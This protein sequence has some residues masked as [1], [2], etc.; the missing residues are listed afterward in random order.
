M[1]GP[2]RTATEADQAAD[3]P[4]S[5]PKRPET[6]S[7]DFKRQVGDKRR[8]RQNL[9]ATLA[10]FVIDGGWVVIGV[11]E[12]EG[13]TP[14]FVPHPVELAGQR[15]RLDSLAHTPSVP[16]PAPIRRHHDVRFHTAQTDL[17]VPTSELVRPYLRV[18]HAEALLDP[19]DPSR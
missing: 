7:V 4:R 10:S 19:P 1:A 9:A 6:H 17:R 15:E 2:L 16:R 11:D 13:Q 12:H 5:D 3:R 8:S 14:R 18:L